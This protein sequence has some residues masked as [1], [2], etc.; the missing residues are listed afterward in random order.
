MAASP[1]SSACWWSVSNRVNLVVR[2]V[3]DRVNLRTKLLALRCRTL[4]EQ[5]LNPV[6]VLLEQRPDLPLV[7]RG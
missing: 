7:F 6:I 2:V 4:I 1:V 5:H 3:A